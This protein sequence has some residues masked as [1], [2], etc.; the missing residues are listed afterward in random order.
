VDLEIKIGGMG[1]SALF[2]ATLLRKEAAAPHMLCAACWHRLHWC[3]GHELFH[4]RFV[5]CACRLVTDGKGRITH[6]TSQLCERLGTTVS[7]M[8]AGNVMHSMDLLL[9]QAFTRIHHQVQHSLT[10]HCR[11]CA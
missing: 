1:D 9:P 5:C 7:K 10:V 8:Q 6:A 2:I 4:M 3:P 11:D